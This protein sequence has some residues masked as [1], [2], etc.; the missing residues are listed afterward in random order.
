ML[1]N[2]SLKSVFIKAKQCLCDLFL[3]ESGVLSTAQPRQ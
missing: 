3:Q 1:E 2:V